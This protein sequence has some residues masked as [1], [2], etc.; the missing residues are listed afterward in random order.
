MFTFTGYLLRKG[1]L[2]GAIL[3]VF[4]TEPLPSSSPL[5]K[6]PGVVITPHISGCTD[7]DKVRHLT[8]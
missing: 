2:G 5:W 4:N 7:P 8:L 6:L 1:W 3:D